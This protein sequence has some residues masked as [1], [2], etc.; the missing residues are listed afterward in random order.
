MK[1]GIDVTP[2]QG[3]LTGV[4]NYI[5]SLLQGLIKEHPDDI[6]YLYCIQKGPLL[7]SLESY[8]VVV[9][10]SRCLGVSEALWSQTTLSW[11]CWRDKI[12][13]FWGSTQSFPLLCRKKQKNII[14][15]YDFAYLLYPQ[16]VSLIKSLY[17]RFFGGEF[18]RRADACMTIS[19]GTANHL[20]ELFFIEAQ[21]VVSPPLKTTPPADSDRLLVKYALQKKRY[22][23]MVGT[24]EP[25][26]NSVAAL[27]AYC[28]LLE[29]NE[30]EPL[31]IVGKKGWR[32][33]KIK[34]KVDYFSRRF[35]HQVKLLG[36]LPNEELASLMQGA[37]AYIMP[38]LYEGYG[39]PIAEARSLGTSVICTSSPEMIE[40]AEGDAT[41]IDPSHFKQEFQQALSSKLPKPSQCNYPTSTELAALLSDLIDRVATGESLSKDRAPRSPMYTHD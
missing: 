26:K 31:V 15:V 22:Y 32:D 12:D 10:V 40:A 9:R 21:C 18:Y 17:L 8:N 1:I 38:S 6:F 11:M 33:K 27:E 36:Y 29:Q 34:K 35:P 24:L 4:G 16:T 14:T 19:Q 7:E 37:K 39:M 13:L 30:M 28:E 5:Y 23:M 25:R 3:E 2:L 41:F 20:R